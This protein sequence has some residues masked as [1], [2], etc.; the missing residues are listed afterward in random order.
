MADQGSRF[1]VDLGE[2]KLPPVVEKQV[3]VEIQAVVLR[4]LAQIN[5]GSQRSEQTR[6]VRTIWDQFPGQTLGLWPGYPTTPPDILGSG[7][8]GP[9]VVEDH[10]TIMK[11]IME[12]PLQVIRAL[13]TQFKS[14]TPARPSGREVL[15][16]ALQVTQIDNYVKARIRAVLDV[17]PQIEDGQAAL[18]QAAKKAV[19]DLRKQLAN[20]SVGDQCRLLRDTGLRSRYRD[21]GGVSE[22]MEVAARMLEDGEDSIYSP[23]HSFYKLLEAGQES[24]TTARDAISDIGSFDTIGA[25]AGGAIGSAAGGVGAG[26]GA[27][28]G[29]LGAS[30]GAAIGH[31]AVAIWDAIFD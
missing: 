15:Q 14:K 22:G 3:E 29:G 16:A 4:A 2:V 27:V 9:L 10:T 28:A 17:L 25:T 1:I 23:D 12:H 26:P 21:H 31:A 18:P 6:V 19:D 30:A 8:E 24:R 5:V 11:A 20:K 7:G 13:P